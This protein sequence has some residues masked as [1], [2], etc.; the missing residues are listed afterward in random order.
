MLSRRH[1]AR[2]IPI[3]FVLALLLLACTLPS[4]TRTLGVAQPAVP[5]PQ[6]PPIAASPTAPP[7][8][9]PTPVLEYQSPANELEAQIESIYDRYAPAVVNITSRTYAYDY[10]MRPVPQEGTGS[11]FVYDERGHIVTNYHV[12]ANAATVSVALA[13]GEVYEAE[14]VGTDPSTDLAVLRIE[15]P[16]LP[17]P[18]PMGDST[19][20][21]VGRFA[22]AIGNPFGLE[23]TLTVGV[24][25]SLGRVIESP[26]GRFIGEAIQTD[27]AVN[28]GN[29]GGPLLNL[30]GEVIGVNSQIISPSQASAGIGFAV[31]AGTVQ[32]VVPALISDGRYPHPWLGV[33]ILDLSPGLV[34]VL[35]RAGVEVGT[36]S[37]VMVVEAVRG[38]P[39]DRAGIRGGQRVV[40]IGNIRLPVGGD[41]IVALSGEPITS[42]RDLNVYLESQTRVG[43]TVT[44]T[45]VRDGQEIALDVTLAE[46]P[47]QQ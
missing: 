4:V 40:S 35:N 22:V 12:V 9:A 38:G 31:S 18:I 10:F 37:G 34:Q 17:A 13:D 33:E 25:S 45:V 23:R 8:P 46:R 43:D 39:A 15:A 14:V 2:V 21:R 16:N 29:S 11:G 32:R 3:L 19:R 24:I 6:S 20:L 47:D 42:L 1:G 26:D 28:P 36:D 41:I 7:T 27:A 44:A 5:T 30:A